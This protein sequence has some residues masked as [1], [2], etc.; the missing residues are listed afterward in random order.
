M[1]EWINQWIEHQHWLVGLAIRCIIPRNGDPPWL[2][3]WCSTWIVADTCI[4]DLQVCI[5]LCSLSQHSYMNYSTFKVLVETIDVLDFF[6]RSIWGYRFYHV[7]SACLSCVSCVL[8]WRL[9][10]DM[11][12]CPWGTNRLHMLG[13]FWLGFWNACPRMI[14]VGQIAAP[15]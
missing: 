3:E 11:I 1:I 14:R 6:L 5:D 12:S 9:V 13:L 4:Y 15:W 2:S 10:S 8:F 7:L